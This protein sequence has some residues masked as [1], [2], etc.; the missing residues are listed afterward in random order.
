MEESRFSEYKI[1]WN[2]IMFDLPTETATQ[3][4]EASNYRKS[5]IKDGY[6]MFQYSIYVRHCSSRE[7]AIVHEQRAIK[8][9]PGDGRVCMLSI[10]DK[11]FANIKIFE[12][13]SKVQPI[14]QAIQLELF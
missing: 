13:S 10:T 8:Q 3:R 1:M 9:I 7:N 11:Q 4:K 2:I 12:G 6:T 14:P 5:L